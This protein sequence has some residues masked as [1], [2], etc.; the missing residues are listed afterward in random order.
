MPFA[1][2]NGIRIEYETMG[3]PKDRPLVLIMG[4]STQLVAWPLRFC[5]LLVEAGHFVVRF[6]NRDAGFSTKMESLGVP[7][8]DKMALALVQGEPVEPPYT[9]STMAQDAVGLMDALKLKTAHIC[10]L[11]MG[12]MI[13][14]VMALEFP[15]RLASLISL[16]STTGER[17]LP[18]STPE[19]TEAMMSK[20]PVRREAYI[21]YQVG[22]YRAFSG[23]SDLYDEN[24]QREL[25]A[26]GYDRMLYPNG[27]VRQ[28][29][30]ILCAPGRRRALSAVKA[31]TL[32][33]HG[34]ND[35]V[36]PAA[37]GEDTAK[38]VPGARLKIFQG[39]GHGMAYPAL[40]GPMADEIAAHTRA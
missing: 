10:G 6:D 21:E 30:A 35:T 28:M 11:S 17:D 2:V 24:V 27:F 18:G 23:K 14:Q 29:A 33:L 8:L 26:L 20:P 9:L 19:A 36:I 25:S 13:A 15:Q 31:P 12:G 39:L 5:R 38:A 40:W 34:A 37:H 4:L 7:D 1:E 16:E 32:V 22:V 3:D